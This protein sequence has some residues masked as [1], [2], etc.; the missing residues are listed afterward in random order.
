MKKL[1]T[2]CPVV[3]MVL[4]VSGGVQAT[5]IE[6]RPNDW[7]DQCASVSTGGDKATQEDARALVKFNGG[8]GVREGYVTWENSAYGYTPSFYKVVQPN[9]INTYHNWAQGLGEG[10]GISGFNMWILPSG[11]TYNSVLSW[12]PKVVMSSMA[13]ANDAGDFTATAGTA[14]N[15]WQWEAIEIYA[16]IYG[17]QWTTE[18]PLKYLRP[19][20]DNLGTFSFTGDFM[21]DGDNNGTGDRALAVGDEI[22]LWL[23]AVNGGVSFDQ[24]SLHFDDNWASDYSPSYVAFNDQYKPADADRY[25]AANA[26]MNVTIPEPA[27]MSLLG[28]GALTLLCRKRKA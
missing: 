16:G 13:A 4:A 26:I 8:S 6:F 1:M 12:G 9:A 17:V 19:G 18:D 15:G 10:E 23:G 11:T 24:D 20:G 7:F 3:T 21:Y 14:G 27:T 25:I 5:T 28:L 2:V 22:R